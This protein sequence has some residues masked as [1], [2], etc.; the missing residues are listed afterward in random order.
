MDSPPPDIL[1]ES[2][3]KN[4]NFMQSKEYSLKVINSPDVKVLPRSNTIKT[5]VVL[6]Q[7]QISKFVLELPKDYT[8]L[9]RYV[10]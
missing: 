8:I 6:S 7:G 4:Y 5:V 1:G 10:Y 9:L 3:K 2:I